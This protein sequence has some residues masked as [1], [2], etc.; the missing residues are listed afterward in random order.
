MIS[1]GAE[2]LLAIFALLGSSFGLPVGVPPGP[3]D[4]AMAKIAPQ[5]CILYASWSP[6]VA[7][8]AQS[9]ATEKWQHHS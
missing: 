1:T 9:N 4:P 7:A 2:M 6:T 3:E 8:D 5:E